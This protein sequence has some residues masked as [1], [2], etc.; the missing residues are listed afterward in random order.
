MI[1]IKNCYATGDVTG[2]GQLGGFAGIC[3][4]YISQC[5][6]TGDVESTDGKAAGFVA[7]NKGKIYDCYSRGKETVITPT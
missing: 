2:Y 6:A 1:V 4:G 5:F 3:G 7:N